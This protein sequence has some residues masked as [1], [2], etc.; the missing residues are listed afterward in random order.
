[1]ATTR[2]VSGACERQRRA[3]FERERISTTI[4]QHT[5]ST[6]DAVSAKEE[7]RGYRHRPGATLNVA[8]PS[9]ARTASAPA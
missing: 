4:A 6:S 9:I 2:C 1:M 3:A 8:A 7:C 5:R